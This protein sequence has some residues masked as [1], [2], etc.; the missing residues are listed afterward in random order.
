MS[1]LETIQILTDSAQYDLCDYSNP[2]KQSSINLPGIYQAT[3]NGCKVPI[4][5]TL[6]S[7]KCQNDCKYCVNQSKRDFHR[8]QLTPEYLSKIF[9][10]YYNKGHVFGLFLSSGIPNDPNETMENLIE[11]AYILRKKY[12]YKDYIHLKIVPGANK[13]TIKRAMALSNRVSIN[14]E[15]ATADG[16]STLSSTKDYNK[17]ILKRLKWI[18][19]LR[20]SKDIFPKS[21][22]TTQ[23]IVGANE[24]TDKEILTRMSKIYKKSELKRA[25]FSPF[26]P[27][28]GTEFENKKNC[29]ESRTNK[30]Y[31]ADKLINTYGYNI[32]ELVFN[33]NDQLYLNEDP[34]ISAAKKM[35]IFPIEINQAPYHDLI[36]VPG[37]GTSSAHKIIAHRHKN[38]FSSYKQLKEI[39]VVINRAEK[40][41][42]INGE[43]Q[44]NLDFF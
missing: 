25:Y 43:L 3:S 12:G 32:K 26:S 22:F 2:N 36:R 38:L 35:N 16:L 8:L 24:E 15:T 37:I 27:V 39:G 17:D 4:F 28:K 13:D 29:S 10:D 31:N 9:I 6:M 44:S 41:I 34:K 30:L 5:K 18:N 11:T 7:N 42:T 33:D 40:Y 1:I 19:S 23:L 20:N 14:I 21:T